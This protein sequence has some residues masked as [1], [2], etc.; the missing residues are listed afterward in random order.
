LSPE[1]GDPISALGGQEP[2]EKN[3]SSADV[4]TGR[5]A[6]RNTTMPDGLYKI[7]LIGTIGF[8]IGAALIGWAYG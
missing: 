4:A 2:P 6:D 1:A 3:G 8:F 7:V 5:F